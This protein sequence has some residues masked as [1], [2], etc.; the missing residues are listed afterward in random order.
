MT[1]FGGRQAQFQIV[2]HFGSAGEFS[3]FLA[4]S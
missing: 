3:I 1:H 4:R 2:A